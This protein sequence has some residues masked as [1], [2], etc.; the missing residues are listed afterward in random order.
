MKN[1]QYSLCE[2]LDRIILSVLCGSIATFTLNIELDES[3]NEGFTEFSESFNN[4]LDEKVRA[5][6]SNFQIRHADILSSLQHLCS[7]IKWSII[8]VAR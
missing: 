6:P 8:F 3:K 1:W 4:D 7:L 2:E 5:T